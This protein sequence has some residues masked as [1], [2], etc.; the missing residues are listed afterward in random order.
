[1]DQFD[2]V[3]WGRVLARLDAQD[4]EIRNLRDDV[5]ALLELAHEGKGGILMLMSV[6][7]GVGAVLGWL[8]EHLFFSRG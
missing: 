4:S 2:P 5:K 7:T 3:Q 1:M 6:G 8:V